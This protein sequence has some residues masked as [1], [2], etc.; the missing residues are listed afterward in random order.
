MMVS[1]SQGQYFDFLIL[2]KMIYSVHQL[3]GEEDVLVKIVDQA[4]CSLSV[5]EDVLVNLSLFFTNRSVWHFSTSIPLCG[6][7]K[8]NSWTVEKLLP[9]DI[10]VIT[11]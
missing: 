5:V 7:I 6:H 1:L 8:G 11:Q 9:G 2:Q 4:I 3:N 10:L